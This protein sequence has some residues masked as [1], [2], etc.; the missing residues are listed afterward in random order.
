MLLSK[1]LSV[2]LQQQPPFYDH[3]TGQPALRSTCIKEM[4]DFVGAKFYC[5]HAVADGKKVKVIVVVI[6]LKTTKMFNG[7]RNNETK[8]SLKESVSQS[9]RALLSTDDNITEYNFH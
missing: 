3:Y 1:I 2:K 8:K 7:C 4:E 6:C 9:V 5:L